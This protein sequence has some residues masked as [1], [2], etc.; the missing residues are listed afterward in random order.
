MTNIPYLL[1]T[2]LTMIYSVRI[3]SKRQITIPV[4]IFNYL[5]L[6]KGDN[7][8]VDI[9]DNKIIMEKSENLLNKLAGSVKVPK[10]YKN[11]SIDFIIREAKKDY[12]N[13][14]K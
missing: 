6:N 9:K 8:I 1:Y 13:K 12:F 7:L 10:K 11:K 3:T 2:F 5:N 14:K 4:K